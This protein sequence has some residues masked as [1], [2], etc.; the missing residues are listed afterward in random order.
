MT[1]RRA[2]KLLALAICAALGI[3]AASAPALAK[4]PAKKPA[5]PKVNDL[6]AGYQR[7]DLSRARGLGDV[8]IS[9]A[10]GRADALLPGRFELPRLSRAARRG[11]APELVERG[12]SGRDVRELHRRD[13]AEPRV[14]VGTSPTAR[15]IRCTCLLQGDRSSPSAGSITCCLYHNVRLVSLMIGANDVFHLHGEHRRKRTGWGSLS[16]AGGRVRQDRVECAPDPAPRSATR[17]TTP[18]QLVLVNYYSLELHQRGSSPKWLIRPTL[19]RPLDRLGQRF[20]ATIANGFCHV[21][22]G[23]CC[24]PEAI[25]ARRACLRMLGEARGTAASTQAMPAQ[26]LLAQTVEKAIRLG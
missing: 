5:A 16:G 19:T 26:A 2:V 8:R 10:A 17:L 1:A 23:G 6:L 9:G 13:R 20:H 22:G 12:V 21:R 11:A 3:A 4:K 18:G 7:L 14:R 25:R 24:A 15:T